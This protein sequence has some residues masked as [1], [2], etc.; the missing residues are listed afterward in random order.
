MV[1][2]MMDDD[3][4]TGDQ[5]ILL[6]SLTVPVSTLSSRLQLNRWLQD[7]CT[8]GYRTV[9]QVATGYLYRWLP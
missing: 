9:V 3:G 6:I 2:A 4:N 5:H 7:T 8:D 1:T